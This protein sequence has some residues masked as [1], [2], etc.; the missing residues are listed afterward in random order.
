MSEIPYSSYENDPNKQNHAL[1]EKYGQ[2]KE[3]KKSYSL[4]SDLELYG[5]DVREWIGEK[6]HRHLIT[7][8][9]DSEVAQMHSRLEELDIHVYSRR[10]IDQS[11]VLEIPKGTKSLRAVSGLIER[12][13]E[14]YS[15]VF[16]LLGEE[17]SAIDRTSL[18]VPSGNWL[19]QFAYSPDPKAEYGAHLYFLPPYNLTDREVD[20][21]TDVG[22]QLA[23]TTNLSET[24][25]IK[26][27][28][29]AQDGWSRD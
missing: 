20:I 5:S 14:H 28:W 8:S 25:I 15:V 4:L 23:D 9:A 21:I 26:L 18:G 24:M 1:V 3:L 13:P 19:D 2:L 7:F 22:S 6:D 10:V 17:I 12:D 11:S 27:M 16:R 29:E